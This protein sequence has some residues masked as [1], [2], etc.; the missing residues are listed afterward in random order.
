LARGD[1]LNAMDGDMFAAIG[2]AFRR[3]GRDPA[4]RAILLSGQGRT[5]PLALDLEYA[6]RQF[7][8]AA[9]PGRAAE[10]RL[11]TSTGCRTPSTRSSRRACR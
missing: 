2:D 11:R 7:P 3:I 9:D 6:A 5:S 10:A 1:K 4:V 8:P